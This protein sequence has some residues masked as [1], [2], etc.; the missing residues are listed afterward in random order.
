MWRSD[1][2][3]VKPSTLITQLP[4]SL[5]NSLV[6]RVFISSLSPCFSLHC[7][8]IPD[9]PGLYHNKYNVAMVTF[10]K[11]PG[12]HH[13]ERIR[14]KDLA[15]ILTQEALLNPI[16]FLKKDLFS[17]FQSGAW[18]SSVECYKLHLC[19]GRKLNA[20]SVTSSCHCVIFADDLT[21]FLLLDITWP[22]LTSGQHYRRQ[23]LRVQYV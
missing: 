11:V 9:G 16:F 3:T 19:R 15:K 17:W 8:Y 10:L 18:W 1:L 5:S 2:V 23:R 20:F 22:R 7:E 4:R 13:A 14:E 6:K 21:N 12:K